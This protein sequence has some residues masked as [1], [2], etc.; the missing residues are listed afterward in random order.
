MAKCFNVDGFSQ[1]LIASC[2]ITA[3]P[4]PRVVLNVVVS[5]LPMPNTFI[6]GDQ[7]SDISPHLL[8]ER[9]LI[10]L[11]A[12]K[13]ALAKTTPQ[14]VRSAVLPLSRRHPIFTCLQ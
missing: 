9:W 4:V 5:D 11:D 8:A 7:Q 14:L 10:E 1:Q 13:Q 3:I 6:S 12:A 2:N